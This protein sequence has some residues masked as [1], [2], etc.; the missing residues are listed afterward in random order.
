MTLAGSN[1]SI[2]QRPVPAR[3]GLLSFPRT[4]P[5]IKFQIRKPKNEDPELRS[6]HFKAELVVNINIDM[7]QIIYSENKRKSLVLGFTVFPR[8]TY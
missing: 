7:F 2:K 6:N 1:L 8:P 3:L 5:L 4:I